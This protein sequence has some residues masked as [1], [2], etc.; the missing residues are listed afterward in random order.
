MGAG[1]ED[2][3]VTVL[4]CGGV[5]GER[6]LR[7]GMVVRKVLDVTEGAL[8]EG[9]RAV[10]GMDLALV[11]ERVTVVQSEFELSKAAGWREVA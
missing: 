1:Q 4:I 2:A 6:K 7:F 10:N 3:V 8:L 9:D 5:D 11:K